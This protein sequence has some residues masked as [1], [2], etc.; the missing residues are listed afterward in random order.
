MQEDMAE[1]DAEAWG[2]GGHDSCALQ[3]LER[4]CDRDGFL[5]SLR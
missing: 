2:T 5:S 1:E 3:L 4:G